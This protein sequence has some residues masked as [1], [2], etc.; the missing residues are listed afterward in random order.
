MYLHFPDDGNYNLLYLN[1]YKK[2]SRLD[3]IARYDDSLTSSRKI[4]KYRKKEWEK[5]RTEREALFKKHP[6]IFKKKKS[7]GGDK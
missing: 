6:N 4:L 1:T 7:N 3:A 2:D 5:D